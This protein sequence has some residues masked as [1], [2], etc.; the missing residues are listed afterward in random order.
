M[1]DA[2]EHP[3]PEFFEIVHIK[4][5]RQPNFFILYDLFGDLD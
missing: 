4:R 1:L 2:L 3:E 5:V